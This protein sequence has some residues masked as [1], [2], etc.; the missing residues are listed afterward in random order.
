MMPRENGIQMYRGLKKD[1]DLKNIPVIVCSGLSKKTFFHSHKLLNESERENVPEP[2][3]YIE[4]PPEADELLA[5]IR[6]SL[7]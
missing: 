2:A 3:A 1:P 7:K 4:K 6:S 5:A